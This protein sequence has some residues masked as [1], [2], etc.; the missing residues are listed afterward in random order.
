MLYLVTGGSG[1]GK[2]QYA[3]NL[4][5]SRYAQTAGQGGRL[6][7]VAAMLP[8]DEESRQRVKSHQD[9]RKDKGFVTLEQYTHIEEIKA[10]A[11]DVILL[12]C[13]SN[14]LANEMY[15]ENG[16]LCEEL[17]GQRMKQEAVSKEAF[18][19]KK[20]LELAE[21]AILTPLQALAKTADSVIVVT[22]E[23]FADGVEY[24][25]ETRCYQRLLGYINQ[26]LAGQAEEAVEIV[27]G[28]PVFIK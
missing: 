1:S 3:E 24:E 18:E 16:R 5:V 19:V 10:G 11:G 28:I 9:M 8:Y 20:L 13:M 14:L 21:K 25:P 6:Y 2:S 17:A 23:I 22:N 4:A 15:H 12:E 26:R 27:C 7:Y